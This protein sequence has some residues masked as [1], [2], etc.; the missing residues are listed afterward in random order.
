[1]NPARRTPRLR[2]GLAA[3]SLAL[4]AVTATSACQPALAPRVVPLPAPPPANA[5]PTPLTV[6]GPSRVTAA[7]LAAWFRSKRIPDARPPVPVEEL[8]GYYIEEGRAEGVAGDRA[9]VQAMIETGWLRFSPRVPPASNNFAG[10]GAVDGGTTALSFPSARIGVRAQIQ[11]LR[12]YADPAATPGRLRNPLVSPR[13]D[14][15]RPKGKAPLWSQFGNG[16]WATDPDYAGK[17]DR[18]YGQ[19]CAF[20]GVRVK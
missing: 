14:L 4:V 1:M 7:Q 15:V 9:F 3:G 20:S 2:R 11:H 8:A 16:V 6:M 12:A 13:F 17:V 18:L 19:L 5:A 10:M